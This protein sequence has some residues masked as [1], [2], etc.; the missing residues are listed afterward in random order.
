VDN[1]FQEVIFWSLAVLSVGAALLV[2]H[3]RNMFRAVL[4]LVVSFLGVAGLFAQMS[5]EFL[6]VVQVLIYAGGIAVLV[7]FAVMLTRDVP[8]GNRNTPVQP[9]A[10]AVGVV[11]LGALIYTIVQAQWNLLPDDLPGPL[12]VVLADTPAGLG[13][14]LLGDF[15]LA[16]EIIGVLLL[17][18]VVGA[19]ALVRER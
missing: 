3:V 2:V 13:E 14:M 10:A 6:A 1:A 15:V 7:V 17:A 12:Q 5:A 18:A 4:L 9:V 16:F 19:L 8:E 11:L